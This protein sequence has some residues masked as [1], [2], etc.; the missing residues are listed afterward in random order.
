MILS[1]V[2]YLVLAL[3]ALRLA[4]FVTT[5][6]LGEW[7]IAGPL[8]HWAWRREGLA[9]V[10]H[11]GAQ[12]QLREWEPGASP[13]PLPDPTWGW[14]SKLVNGLDCGYC[15]TPWLSGALIVG[16][17]TVGRIPVVKQLWRLVT[18][19]LAASYVLGHVWARMDKPKD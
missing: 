4:R 6:K 16:E 3:T 11:P 8:V 12:Q 13:L 17:A 9:H 19:T 1:V 2:R 18:V 15:L 14:R 7:T 5:D 10:D